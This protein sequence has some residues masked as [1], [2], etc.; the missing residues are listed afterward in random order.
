MI[1]PLTTTAYICTS[2][3]NLPAQQTTS[4][5]LNQLAYEAFGA[6]KKIEET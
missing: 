4:K 5:H 3:L 2:S 1:S 6:G